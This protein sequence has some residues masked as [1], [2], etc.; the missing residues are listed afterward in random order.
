MKFLKQ[1]TAIVGLSLSVISCAPAGTG[2]VSP[3]AN[4]GAQ[5]NMSAYLSE[6]PVLTDTSWARMYQDYQ[7]ES[8][9]M[10]NPGFLTLAKDS[11]RLA[12]TIDQKELYLAASV[13][14]AMPEEAKKVNKT[15][16]KYLRQ[17]GMNPD[18]M[19]AYQY[20][21]IVI[22]PTHGNCQNG[23]AH[24]SIDMK[25]NYSALLEMSV[26]T[27]EAT[28][29]TVFDHSVWKRVI[30]VYEQGV[31][32]KVLRE[33]SYDE[34][35]INR[36]YDKPELQAYADKTNG[37]KTILSDITYASLDS[38]ANGAKFQTIQIPLDNNNRMTTTST[39]LFQFQ[40]DNVMITTKYQGSH[41]AGVEKTKN[42]IFHGWN[43][44]Y[45]HDFQLMGQSIAQAELTYGIAQEVVHQNVKLI[46]FKKCYQNGVQI[47][48]ETCAD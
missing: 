8:K 40:P 12:C 4:A 2:G 17:Q 21:N 9:E 36:Y 22:T 18:S 45:L 26:T 43:S 6:F 1:I 48:T 15:Y 37:K 24:G 3:A 27:P 10:Y 31:F 39:Q 35:V 20:R 11:P 46:Q 14:M 5:A 23:L 25:V 42:G 7:R 32:V 28:V 44:V 34:S 38:S 13:I 19:P 41:L 47:K 30:A 16:R 29:R 33:Y